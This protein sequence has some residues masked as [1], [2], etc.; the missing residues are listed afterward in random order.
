[1]ERF[2]YEISGTAANGQTWTTRGTFLLSS[3]RISDAFEPAMKHSFH[4]L[5][6]GFAIYGKRGVGCKGSYQVNRFI[7]DKESN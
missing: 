3:E 6:N 1:M 7:I 4:Q 2:T 5:V